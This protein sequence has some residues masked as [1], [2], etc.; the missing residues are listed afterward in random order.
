MD[1]PKCGVKMIIA[2]SEDTGI[3]IEVLYGCPNC[4]DTIFKILTER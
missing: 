2:N 3:V 1:C 4:G